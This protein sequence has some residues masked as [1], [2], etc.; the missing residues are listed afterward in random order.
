[1]PRGETEKDSLIPQTVPVSPHLS[2]GERVPLEKGSSESERLFP[3]LKCTHS[4]DLDI[5]SADTRM[6]LFNGCLRV[7]AHENGIQVGRTGEGEKH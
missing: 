6:D 3:Q 7:R 1:M 2:S 4:T 5:L